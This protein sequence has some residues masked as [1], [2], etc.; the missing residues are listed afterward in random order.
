MT[1]E[2]IIIITYFQELILHAN[3]T[4]QLYIH[5]IHDQKIHIQEQQCSRKYPQSFLMLIEIYYLLLIT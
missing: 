5:L 1:D 2:I 4:K 3:N